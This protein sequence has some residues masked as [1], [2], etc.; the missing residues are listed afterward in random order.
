MKHLSILIPKGYLILDTIVGTLNLFRM[1]NSYSR[2]IGKTTTDVF[3][4][5]L[6]AIDKDPI[7]CHQYFQVQ[8]TKTLAEVDHTGLIILTSI[9]GNLEKALEEN[10]ELINWIR[11]QRIKNST[12]IASLCRSA[13]L[14]AD[15]GLL[16]GKSCTTHWAVEE[17]FARRFP[18]I[19]L[20]SNKIICEDNGIYSSGGAYSFLNIVIYLIEKFYG[21]EVAIWCSKMAEIDFDRANQNQFAIFR[22]QKEHTDSTIKK[23]Q[24]YIEENFEQKLNIDELAQQFQ[25]SSRSFIRRFKKATQN[26]PFEYIQR[27]RM[28]V[29]KKNFESTPLNVNQV[30]YEVGYIDEKAFRKTFK[31][32]TGLS[33]IEYRRKFNREMAMA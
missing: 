2:R 23:V 24:D 7:S 20:L 32:H 21:R 12:E 17:K 11:N 25:L 29:A 10:E 13:Y 4:I 31:K 19:Q 3:E 9:T 16:N 6:V 15:T 18:K 14:L 30:M 26:T 33:P 5:D 22:G 27:V 1:A 8:P 28:E